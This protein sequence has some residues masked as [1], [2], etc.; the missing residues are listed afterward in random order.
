LRGAPSIMTRGI[1][2]IA[3]YPH[4]IIICIGERVDSGNCELELDALSSLPAW[5][6]ACVNV[7][8]RERDPLL[9]GAALRP[10]AQGSE[11]ML[12]LRLT[13]ILILDRVAF[14]NLEDTWIGFSTIQVCNFAGARTRPRIFGH[15]EQGDIQLGR[16]PYLIHDSDWPVVSFRAFRD[17]HGDAHT[18]RIDAG[19]GFP[20]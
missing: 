1:G 16:A 17:G 6:T 5:R 9:P 20:A 12:L 11:N 14:R 15:R 3:P 10:P 8:S 18:L 13:G 2:I 4:G 19:N 7:H